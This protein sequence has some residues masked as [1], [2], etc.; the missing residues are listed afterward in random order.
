MEYRGLPRVI[1]GPAV[2]AI[3]LLA[4]ASLHAKPVTIVVDTE[5]DQLDPCQ[6]D[7]SQVGPVIKSNV[8]ETL[9]EIDPFDGTVLPR[10]ATEW[11]RLDATTWQFD[12]RGGVTFH[13]G[14]PLTAEAV[15]VSMRRTLVPE[16]SCESALKYF[17]AIKLTAEPVDDDTVRFTTD[18]P[19]E[20]LPTMMASVGIS[21][22]ATPLNEI[23]RAPIGT[24]PY[25]LSEWVPGQRVVLSA[26][27]GYW[28][29]PAEVTGATYVWRQ[30]S[31]VRAAMVAAGEA[32]IAP[33]IAVQDATDGSMDFAYSNAVTTSFRID[34]AIAP[35]DDVRVRRAANLAID[36]D[37]LRGTLFSAEAIP[38]AQQVPPGATGYNPELTPY[39]FDPGEARR[40]LAAARADGAPVDTEIVLIGRYNI[41]SNAEEVVQAVQAMLAD[42]GFKTSIKMTD[43]AEWFK[44]ALKPF[45][46]GRAPNIFQTGHDN[47]MG[48]AVFT[49]PAKYASTERQA[50]MTV[51][52][53][54]RL[55]AEASVASG[56]ERRAKFAEALRMIHEDIVPDI[57]LFHMVE[58]ARVNPRITY[59][60]NVST[61]TALQLRQISFK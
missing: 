27:P 22:L 30:D 24:G 43:S 47:T 53:L 20:I 40:L 39:A 6:I 18:I 2:L 34:G 8:I 51:P 23:T 10:L 29:G 31:A 35:L 1:A 12:L 19:V 33:R 15:A 56:E 25:V 5:P 9:T 7:K 28:G 59:V 13:D 45:A 37:A 4:A 49:V 57:I 16:L 26:Y 42:V 60:P 21:S 55:I 17:A 50:T 48:D 3:S 44:L 61:G 46:E 14:S 32:D 36:R 38:A 11:V 54:D 52:E 41:Y 58:F